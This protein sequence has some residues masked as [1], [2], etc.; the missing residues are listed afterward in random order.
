MQ[1]QSPLLTLTPTLDG[2]V[3]SVLAGADDWFTVSRIH[4]RLPARSREGIRRT[5]TRLSA[6]GVVDSTSVGTTT[7]HRLNRDHLAAG[8]IL[9]LTALRSTLLDRLRSELAGWRPE[10]LFSAV[11]GSA[12]TGHMR[13]DSDI[14]LFVLAPDDV[15]DH[16][17][18][19]IDS[20]SERSRRWTGNA[21]HVLV[22]SE[23]EVRGALRR[24]PV[25]D[26]IARDGLPV[27]GS[28]HAFR[29]LSRAAS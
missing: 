4:A 21:L 13:H 12:A 14:D 23:S 25:L 27:T 11:F 16:W 8:P 22:M 2:E 18:A 10:P 17:D 3:L 9:E 26:D 6:Q 29:R 1:L 24:E 20:L 5:L 28:T 7:S 15:A 19:S